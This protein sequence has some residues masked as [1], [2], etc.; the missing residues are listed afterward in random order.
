MSAL[1]IIA[2]YLRL[3]IPFTKLLLLLK[4]ACYIFIT[5]N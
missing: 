1:T 2:K 3:D 5:Q 4:R